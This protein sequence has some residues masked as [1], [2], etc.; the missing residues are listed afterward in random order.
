VAGLSLQVGVEVITPDN[1]V[2]FLGQNA[3]KAALGQS[4]AKGSVVPFMGKYVPVNSLGQEERDSRKWRWIHY[5]QP[6]E[7]VPVQAFWEDMRNTAVACFPGT[8][9]GY[10]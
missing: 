6:R 4:I 1:V 7:K 9:I 2:M 8:R 5:G 10:M 3:P